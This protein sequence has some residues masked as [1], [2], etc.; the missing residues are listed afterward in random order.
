MSL[1]PTR[2]PFEFIAMELLDQLLRSKAG[3]VWILVITNRYF[4]LARAL[5]HTS[6]TMCANDFMSYCV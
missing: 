1:L 5:P 3:N 2:G 6:A 4:R